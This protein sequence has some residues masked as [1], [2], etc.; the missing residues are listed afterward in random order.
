MSALFLGVRAL[1]VGLLPAAWVLLT[2][3]LALAADTTAD[4]AYRV[5]VVAKDS[6]NGYVALPSPSS[7][8][9]IQYEYGVPSLPVSPTWNYLGQ[10]FFLWGDID[11]DSYGV[12]GQFKLSN[13]PFNQIVPEIMTGLVLAGNDA[14]YHPTYA[15][16]SS[17]VLQAEYFWQ[18]QDGTPYSQTGALVGIQPGDDVKTVIQYDSNSGAITATISAREGSSTIVIPRPFPNETPPLFA[19]WRDFFDQAAAKSTAVY[20][21]PLIDI[22]SHNLPDPGALCSIVPWNIL[23]ISIPGVAAQSQSYGLSTQG[24]AFS[25]DRAL[26]DL[27]FGG[28]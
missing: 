5:I 26:V 1:G 3:P 18:G 21:R 9:V 15:Q 7:S 10:T 25:C 16:L 13:Y 2:P 4:T 24:A 14:S 12:L 8:W 22:E 23:G 20:G 19:S 28:N 27:K 17:W 11:F 6:S